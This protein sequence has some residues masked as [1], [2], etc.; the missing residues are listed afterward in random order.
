MEFHRCDKCGKEL[1]RNEVNIVTLYHRDSVA[2]MQPGQV[3]ETYS[4][5]IE[6]CDDDYS[7]VLESVAGLLK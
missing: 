5:T 3:S 7:G 4:A 6:L 2:R 1:D